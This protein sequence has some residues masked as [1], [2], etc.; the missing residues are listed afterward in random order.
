LWP[1]LPRSDRTGGGAATIAKDVAV[2]HLALLLTLW[3]HG[4]ADV[5]PHSPSNGCRADKVR[6]TWQWSRIEGADHGE[7]RNVLACVDSWLRRSELRSRSNGG[8][9]TG[10]QGK[11]DLMWVLECSGCMRVWS[12]N[13]R[14][15]LSYLRVWCIHCCMLFVSL[16][17]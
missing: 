12:Q 17:S 5:R 4:S 8:S 3:L 14:L 9:V 6:K 2:A 13:D 10:E 7:H 16:I 11:G 15:G 1:P